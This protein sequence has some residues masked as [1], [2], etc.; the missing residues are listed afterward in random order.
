MK[1]LLNLPTTTTKDK[2]INAT[3][4]IIHTEGLKHVTIRKITSLAGVNIAAINYHFGSK[5]MVINEALKHVT[6][7]MK[8][9][10]SYLEEDNV[11]PEIRLKNFI[12][13]YFDTGQ[14]YPSILKNF[15]NHSMYNHCV[16][17]EFE[18]Y[19]KKRGIKLLEKTLKE[20]LPNEKNLILHMK[21][22][23]ILSA[24]SL[25]ILIGNKSEKM[26]GID[27][28]DI[29]TKDAYIDLLLKSILP[30]N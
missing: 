5:A 2:I 3:L 14:K 26:L 18:I 10:F 23:Q 15:I 28:E 16:E 22:L 27:Y 9:A 20:I 8:K 21:I 1:N 25:P 13:N 29:K 6:V 12:E 4:H 19:M 30:E 11:L 17:A 7:Q 24:L